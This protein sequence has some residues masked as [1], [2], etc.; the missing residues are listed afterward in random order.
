LSLTDLKVKNDVHNQIVHDVIR[1]WSRIFPVTVIICLKIHIVQ[2][3]V[4]PISL[5]VYFD[6]L[7]RRLV[8]FL[9]SPHMYCLLLA[10]KDTWVH[11]RFVA[12][13]SFL[14]LVF[15]NSV[16]SCL[17]S[18]YYGLV[19]DLLP[20]ITFMCILTLL[21]LF[22]ICVHKNQ[23]LEHIVQNVTKTGWNSQKCKQKTREKSRKNN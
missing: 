20:L 23:K 19:I 13:F 8:C 11:R 3:F 5:I 14:W 10:F 16:C 18:L 17:F 7:F 22:S 2:C 1:A 15:L 6:P 4:V 21:R 9:Y 12:L